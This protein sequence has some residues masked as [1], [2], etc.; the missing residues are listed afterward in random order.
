MAVKDV[1][2]DRD[3]NMI[4]KIPVKYKISLGLPAGHKTQAHPNGTSYP[5][6]LFYFLPQSRNEQGEWEYDPKLCKKLFG[7]DDIKK[8]K[9][10]EIKIRL[11]GSDIEDMLKS[12]LFYWDTSIGMKCNCGTTKTYLEDWCRRNDVK[13]EPPL[14]EVRSETEL[15]YLIR[16]KDV[17]DRLSKFLKECEDY[18]D[19][20]YQLAKMYKVDT[21]YEITLSHY[22]QSSCAIRRIEGENRSFP[23]LFRRCPDYIA[24]KCKLNARFFFA[25]EGF[26]STDVAVL[27]T[28]SPKL[29]KQL[30]WGLENIVKNVIAG[31]VHNGNKFIP[32]F[33]TENMVGHKLGEFSHTR[34]FRGH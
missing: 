2:H 25:F 20:F 33:I 9:P 30:Q 11:I 28:T 5:I 17:S 21:D 4:T 15:K 27:V 12:D 22:I 16:N 18:N 1:S 3:G 13:W 26:D 7:S 8:I 24:G 19:K 34:T 10:R 23:C 14:S 6:K 29:L 31:R 32:I